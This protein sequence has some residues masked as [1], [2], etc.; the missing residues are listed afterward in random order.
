MLLISKIIIFV[1]AVIFVFDGI[2]TMMGYPNLIN[3]AWPFPCPLNV[4]IFGIGLI[5]FLVA[6]AAHRHSS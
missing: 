4:T 3:P 5:L 2:K 6:G 1:C